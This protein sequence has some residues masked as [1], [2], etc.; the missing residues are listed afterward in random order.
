[1]ELNQE[2]NKSECTY[3]AGWKQKVLKLKTKNEKRK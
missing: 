1:M 3:T 2:E